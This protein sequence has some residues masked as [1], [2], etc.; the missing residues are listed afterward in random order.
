MKVKRRLN[1]RFKKKLF[2]FASLIFCTATLFAQFDF[3]TPANY[4]VSGKPRSE[5]SEVRNVSKLMVKVKKSVSTFPLGASRVAIYKINADPAS[6]SSGMVRF[7]RGKLEEIILSETR[8]ELVTI[9]EFNL[10][11]V[12][13]TDTSFSFVNAARNYPELRA[14]GEKYNVDAFLE[15]FVTRGVHGDVLLTFKLMNSKTG[16]ILWSRSFIEGPNRD[17]DIVN[18]IRYRFHAAYKIYNVQE[19]TAGGVTLLKDENGVP[20]SGHSS[21]LAEYS[22]GFIREQRA[23]FKKVDFWLV[24]GVSSFNITAKYG[25]GTGTFDP[26][27]FIEL[28]SMT[29]FYG[30]VGLSGRIMEKKQRSLEDLNVG[31]WINP[32]LKAKFYV[33]TNYTTEFLAFDAGLLTEATSNIFVGFGIGYIPQSKVIYQYQNDSIDFEAL[34]YEIQLTYNF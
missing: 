24:G 33:P 13:I 1:I 16:S 28:P 7:I 11:K 30:G 6:I 14:L 26:G 18:P 17:D 10:T 21:T 19:Y 27:A 29:A 15:G 34:N 5:Q 2:L 4:G 23:A 31:Y 8:I 25:T 32:Y 20:R 12:R 22:L 9:P 3:Q